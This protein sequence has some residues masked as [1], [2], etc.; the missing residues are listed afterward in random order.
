MSSPSSSTARPLRQQPLGT[1]LVIG[2]CGFLGHHIVQALSDS[3]QASTIAV[4]DLRTDR[5][6]LSSSSSSSSNPNGPPSSSSIQYFDADI[7]SV[8][9]ILPI[10]QQV[11]PDVVIHTASP[12]VMGTPKKVLYQVN[13]E[14]T[15][16]LVEVA[17]RKD[18]GCKAFVYTSSPSVIS[19]GK[20]DLVNADERWPYVADEVQEEYY[21]QTKAE[22]ERFVISANRSPDYSYML[23]T[24]LRP[25]SMIGEGDVQNIP[26]VLQAYK[27]GQ[28]GWQLGS[29]NNLFDFTYVGNVAHAHLLASAA[30]LR[31]L[32]QFGHPSSS[33]TKVTTPLDHERID[34]EVFF[35]TNDS[36]IYFWDFPR[37]VWRA[38]GDKRKVPEDVRHIP[39]QTGLVL[40][41]LAEW[42]LG[43][44]GKTPNLTRQ[45]VKYTSMT[46]YFNCRKARERLGYAPLVDLEEGVNRAVRWVLEME[47]LGEMGE[48]KEGKKGQ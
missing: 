37:L 38:A 27:K 21:A 35:I 12:T 43:L 9:S 25:A 7:T 36:P 5:N 8:S 4:L 3:G 28:T 32:S 13:V 18:V 34:G 46:R 17:G 47:R 10:F 29:N 42:V 24:S 1:V 44:M 26:S 40:A 48:K 11:K 6:R 22:A 2:G 15:K 41:G 16:N 33:T 30:L 14:G 31:T 39:V 45:R 20:S 19:D 23:T